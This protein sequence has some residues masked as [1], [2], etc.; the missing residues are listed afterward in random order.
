MRKLE[1]FL[2]KLEEERKKGAVS[3]QAYEVL[4]KEYQTKIKRLEGEI[5]KLKK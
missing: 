2:A 4:K 3:E 1:D 5:E